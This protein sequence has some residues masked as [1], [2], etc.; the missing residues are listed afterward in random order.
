[1]TMPELRELLERATSKELLL[2]V[3]LRVIA[4]SPSDLAAMPV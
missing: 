3:L 4:S 2:D 1:M